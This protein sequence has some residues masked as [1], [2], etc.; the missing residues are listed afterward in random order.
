M[1]T[2][3]ASWPQPGSQECVVYEGCRWAGQFSAI[4]ADGSKGKCAPGAKKMTGGMNTPV[5][6]RFTPKT[7]ANMR[8]ASTTVKDFKR[9]RGRSLEV[10]IEGRPNVTT[11]VTIRDNCN[12]NDCREDNC[13][14]AYKGCCAKHS[15]NFKYTLLDL[16]TNPASD[17]LGVD[18]TKE[19]VGGPY[20]MEKMP[21]WA[22][23]IR[24]GLRECISGNNTMPLCYRIKK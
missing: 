20:Q 17:L 11:T 13:G 4:S 12:D 9:L 23:N 1:G 21:S 7:V 5:E 14:G 15:D 10:M 3:Y 6:C 8:M 22:L 18:L 24:P 19:D 2:L 16:E